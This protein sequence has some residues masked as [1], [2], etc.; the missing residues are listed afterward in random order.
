MT[1]SEKLRESVDHNKDDLKHKSIE[2]AKQMTEYVR[3]ET[4]L[5]VISGFMN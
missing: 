1:C 3:K 2:Y 5:E 4:N